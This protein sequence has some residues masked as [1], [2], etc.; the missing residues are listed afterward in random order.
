MISETS[1]KGRTNS[2]MLHA[3]ILVSLLFNCEHFM[4]DLQLSMASFLE[5]GE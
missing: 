5:D 2:Y 3:M 4:V 1:R